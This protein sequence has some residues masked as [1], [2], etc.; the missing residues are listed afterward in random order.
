[1]T[2]AIGRTAARI[3]SG[4]G[5][6]LGVAAVAA[7]AL[8]PSAGTAAA[9]RGAAH[10]AFERGMQLYAEG[11]YSGAVDAFNE[12]VAM[13]VEDP[14]VEY[15]LANAWFKAGRLGR[16]IY[17][18]RR[19]HALAPRDE[20]VKANLEYARFLALD[21][22][23]E[24]GTT[25]DRRVEGWLDRVTPEEAARVP[26]ALW[27]AAG[28]AFLIFL[29]NLFWNASHGWPTLQHTAEISHLEQGALHWDELTEFLGGQF[30]VFGPLA[31]VLWLVAARGVPRSPQRTV[32]LAF[33]LVFLFVIAA[34]AL[35]GRANANWAAP[36]FVA[37]SVLVARWG[38]TRP[39]MI[40]AALLVNAV[41]M[42][43]AYHYEAA[44]RLLGV[45][46]TGKSDPF[47]RVRGWEQLGQQ[48]A[49][50]R[51]EAP[52]ARLMSEDREVLAQMA[53]QLRLAS[54]ELRSW[55]PSGL[56]RHQYDLLYSLEA[57]DVG[58][59]V[60][61]VTRRGRVDDVAAHFSEVRRL[62]PLEHAV[63]PDWVRHY[64]VYWLKGYKG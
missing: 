18:Y 34:Q 9:D 32:L 64:E 16:A 33:T 37:A 63:H 56:L 38:L 47:K 40:L 52:G 42:F 8:L 55:N 20:D 21:R 39:R 62:A 41:L 15:D 13:G 12:V 31:L 59:D 30:V 11:D 17:H 27:I 4:G 24:S 23:D 6:L 54:G 10:A 46:L 50:R 22:I 49:E 29:P 45:E 25:T 1:M 57:G 53:W 14:A 26:M 48:F 5:R 43:G 2:R 35:F 51:A 58:S 61:Y 3:A 19:A 7:A 44:A 28:L 36:A 60:L